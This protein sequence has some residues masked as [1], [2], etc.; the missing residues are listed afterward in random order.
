MAR[1]VQCVKFGRE[2]PGLAAAPFPGPLGER[3]YN[4]VSQQA[5]NLWPA[6]ATLIINHYG[7][8]LADPQ[9]QKLLLQAMEDFFFGANAPLPEGWAPPARPA[10]GGAPRR[11]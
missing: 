8:N 4:R 6:Q 5:W 1:M 11:K 10:K 7:L 3:I 9:A 2:L